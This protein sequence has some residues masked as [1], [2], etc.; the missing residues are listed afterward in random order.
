MSRLVFF[1][2]MRYVCGAV[3]VCIALVGQAQATDVVTTYKDDN[4]W[5]LQVNGSDFYVKGVV[6]GYSPRNENFNYNLW[7]QSDDFVRKVLDY[8]FR[9]DAGGG[10][11]RDP[12]LSVIMPPNG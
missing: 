8:E 5:K 10:R 4:G 3:L 1:R 7:G 2:G 9:L 6:W 11:Q 12:Q